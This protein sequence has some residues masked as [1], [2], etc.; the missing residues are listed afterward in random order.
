MI[1]IRDVP[2]EIHLELRVRAAE[3]GVSLSQ[4]LRDQ[5]EKLAGQRT[6]AEVVADWQ[7]PRA[8]L[9]RDE[10]VDAVRQGRR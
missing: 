10:I 5:L 1:Q 2:E 3:A 9:P 4:Y 6:V 8:E 7:G